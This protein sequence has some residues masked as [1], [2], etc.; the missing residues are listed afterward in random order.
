MSGWLRY[1]ANDTNLYR[2]A[3]GNVYIEFLDVKKE[4]LLANFTPPVRDLLDFLTRRLTEPFF[5]WRVEVGE[6][7]KVITKNSD[8]LWWYQLND[9]VEVAGF[10]PVGGSRLFGTL[11]AKGTHIS[12]P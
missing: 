4:N 8:G 5:K 6:K 3:S 2:L 10:T 12:S 1:G 7:Y 9:I 11:S